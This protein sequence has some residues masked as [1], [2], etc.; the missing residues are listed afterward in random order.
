[1]ITQEQQNEIVNKW[2]DDN[3]YNVTISQ[4]QSFIAGIHAADEYVE[5]KKQSPSFGW[6]NG[7]FNM[8]FEK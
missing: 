5:T 6:H 3:K 7:V 8:G 1:M 2:L 4:L